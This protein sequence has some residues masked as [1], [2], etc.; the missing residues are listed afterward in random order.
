MGGTREWA[1]PSADRTE[2]NRAGD[3]LIQFDFD[4]PALW[5]QWDRYWRALSVINN[6]RSSHSY[7]LNTFQM[8]LRRYAAKVDRKALVAQRIKRLSSIEA[9]LRRFPKMRLTQMQDVGGCRGVVSSIQ[10]V[11][12]LLEQ[13]R[14]SGIKHEV[15][16][17]DDYIQT[18]KS[19][20]YRGVH[21]VYRYYSD[22]DKQAYNGLKIEIQL[23]SQFQHAWATAVETVGT[24]VQQ[25]LKSS[26]G[27]P[28]WLRFFSLM[29]SVIAHREGTPTVPGTPSTRT[30][31]LSELRHY[32]G[33]LQVARRLNAY[34]NALK[35]LG[36]ESADGSDSHY[37]LLLLD[38]VAGEVRVRGFNANELSRASEEY[39]EAEK[40]IRKKP[41][42]DAVLVSADSVTA[43]ERAYP[44]YFADT[45]VFLALLG[46]ALSKRP[47]KPISIPGI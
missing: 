8:T 35:R 42:S 18:P 14:N 22:K 29:G 11:T 45:R 26:Q 21:L 36:T 38:P 40:Q 28:N 15:A 5:N 41:T 32:A 23:R 43:L 9:K 13:Y 31:L 20:G 27:E 16:S 34:R 30:D 39:L 25:A 17:A 46:Q 4:D 1:T 2:V 3:T 47:A 37:Y 24:F 19:S 7:P 12:A 33:A 10:H 6:W 44:N